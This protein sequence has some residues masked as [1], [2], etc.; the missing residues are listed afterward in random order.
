M[1]C[2]AANHLI[3]GSLDAPL[4][5]TERVRLDAHL[6]D[7][8][9]CRRAWD[10]YR[11]LAQA[12]T[13]WSRRSGA[14]ETPPDEFTAQV[15]ARIAARPAPAPGPLRPRLL[16][17][18]MALAVLIA[19][20]LWV[21]PLLPPLTGWRLAVTVPSPTI[22]LDVLAQMLRAAPQEARGLW[23][24]ADSVVAAFHWAV[25]MLLL[26]LP[27]N[28]LLCLRARRGVRRAA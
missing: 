16:E 1:N 6:A 27:V 8:P 2:H 25:L 26:A 4:S 13:V 12:A 18:G 14:S 24:A 21:S 22:W 5:A 7:C 9:A 23:T 3:Q 17:I 10:E 20:S 11:R 15:L 19:L 28:V